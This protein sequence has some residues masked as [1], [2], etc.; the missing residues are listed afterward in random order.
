[1]SRKLKIHLSSASGL[2]A[3]DKNGK[4][5]PYVT[6]HLLEKGSAKEVS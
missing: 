2:L 3:A 4:S 5:D 1:M 6:I